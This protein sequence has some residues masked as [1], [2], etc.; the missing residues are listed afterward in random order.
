MWGAID[1]CDRNDMLFVTHRQPPPHS[2]THSTL[3]VRKEMRLL[4]EG[5]ESPDT[6]KTSF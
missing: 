2:E 1:L 4:S 5:E 3:R 6:F